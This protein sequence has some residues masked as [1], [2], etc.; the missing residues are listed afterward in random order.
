MPGS[1]TGSAVPSEGEPTMTDGTQPTAATI[2]AEVRV[3]ASPP[4]T[5]VRLRR[6]MKDPRSSVRD[7]VDAVSTDPSLTARLL[8]VANSAYF[9]G[10]RAVDTI[11]RA[12]VVLGNRQIHDIVLATSVM[13]R[14]SRIPARLVDM[15]GFWRM[16]LFAAAASRLLADRC[17]IFDS[18]RLFV[19]G[20]L[21]QI[22]QLVLYL[23]VPDAMT[24]VLE[25][26][27]G[28]DQPIHLVERELLGFDYAAVSGELFAAWK[29]PA[30]LVGPIRC[31]TDPA[32]AGD[33]VLEALVVGVAVGLAADAGRPTRLA[34]PVRDLSAASLATLGLDAGDLRPLCQEAAELTREAATVFL[35]AA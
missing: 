19:A 4:G 12:V 31:H 20:L 6:V 9:G 23:R 22:G 28:E 21:A 29:L 10:G 16:S 25:I 35:A 18:E 24:R 15:N 32:T 33:H 8:R 11:E 7:L 27:Q 3:L 34:N 17:L 5:Y 26:A 30:S 1:M 2:A 13:S 14:F